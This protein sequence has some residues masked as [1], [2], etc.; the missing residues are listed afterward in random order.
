M[1]KE[2]SEEELRR[3]AEKA[4]WYIEDRR[5][6]DE[7]IEACETIRALIA[8]LDAKIAMLESKA[9]R[10][11]EAATE[12]HQEPRRIFDGSPEGAVFAEW[13]RTYQTYQQWDE[14][15]RGGAGKDDDGE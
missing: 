5:T 6:E 3:A 1:T 11:F 12:M 13:V 14:S 15:Q 9:E 2:P 7:D 10:A 4:L 8:R